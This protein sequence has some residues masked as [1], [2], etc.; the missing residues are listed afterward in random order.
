MMAEEFT[1]ASIRRL[2]KRGGEV[3]VSDAAANA[4]RNA[5][6]EYGLRLAKLAVENAR[7][8]SRNTV[9]ERDIVEALRLIQEEG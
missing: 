7:R 3:K 2:L 6:G 1:L 9:L 5:L 8:E 4:L